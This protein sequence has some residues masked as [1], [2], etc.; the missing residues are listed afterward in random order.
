MPVLR[1]RRAV[2]AHRPLRRRRA[3]QAPG[4][5][6]RRHGA[7]DDQRGDGHHACRAGRAQL[8]RP[9]L[10]AL[11]HPGQGARRAASPRRRAA[12][13]RVH[14]E[15]LLLLRPRRAT[16]SRSATR[17][18]RAPT[19]AS[20]TARAW[21]GTRVESDVGMMGGIGAHEYMAPCPAGENEVAL[22]PGYAAN[23]E[24]ASAEPQP[25]PALPDT[26]TG[27]LHTPGAST[28]EA[29]AQAL[30][31]HPGTLLKAFPVVTESRGLLL[32]MVRGDH[33]VNDIKLQNALG[34]AFRPAREDEL[35][36]QGPGRW[37]HRSHP[38]LQR[39]RR[40]DP[41]RCRRARPLRGRR[42]QARLPRRARRARRRTPGRP[43]RGRGRH[44][45]RPVRSA[46]SRPSRSATSS[47]SARATRC[48]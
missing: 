18:T 31:V 44:G 27:E 28:I 47:S 30:D 6:G 33:R 4:P 2:E 14:H 21:S 43:H 12:H 3:V 13:S 38:T 46:S 8:P 23:V 9:A 20:S 40:A 36:E 25:V 5:Q 42:Q 17:R 16:A 37:I 11:P 22:A 15:G 24:V 34:E 32:V 48:R 41:R 7:V 1:A 10:L 45:R 19:T 26:V 29:L 39:R 35:A